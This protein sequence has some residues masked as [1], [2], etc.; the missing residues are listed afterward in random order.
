MNVLGFINHACHLE[1][2]VFEEPYSSDVV[3]AVFDYFSKTIDKPTDKVI[4]NAPTHT[5]DFFLAHIGDWE[6]RGLYVIPL[7]AE[8]KELSLRQNGVLKEQ[9]NR[10]MLLENNCLI[11]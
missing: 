7:P 11:F 3:V 8:S 2:V 1:S 4:D 10:L 6:E 9:L 5:S